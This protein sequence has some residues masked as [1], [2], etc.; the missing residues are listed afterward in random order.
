MKK[1]LVILGFLSFSVTAQK[2]IRS[3]KLDSAVFNEI[4]KVRRENN[5]PSVLKFFYG[6][7][8]EFSYTVTDK[9][10]DANYF[11]HSPMDSTRKYCNAECI[12]QLI[13]KSDDAFNVLSIIDIE[14]YPEKIAAIAFRIVECWMNSE[15]HRLAILRPWNRSFTITSQIE[16]LDDGKIA[17]LSVSYHAVRGTCTLNELPIGLRYNT[18][19]YLN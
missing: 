5:K 6:K 17:V 13:I 4:A 3:I 19:Y 12:Y 16:I 7:I 15:S 1:L 10:C 9:N 11:K 8:R 14:L 2:T 18:E